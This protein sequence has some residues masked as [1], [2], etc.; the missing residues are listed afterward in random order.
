LQ[1]AAIK[2]RF[3]RRRMAGEEEEQ[4]REG[5]RGEVHRLAHY[6]Q[7]S[8]T[9]KY[10]K[11]QSDTAKYSQTLCGQTLHLKEQGKAYMIFIQ[12]HSHLLRRL[13]NP[14]KAHS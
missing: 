8:N 7:V 6:Q 13:C 10:S 2:L 9:A 12:R 1:S 5:E 4:T 3:L 11:I 14:F